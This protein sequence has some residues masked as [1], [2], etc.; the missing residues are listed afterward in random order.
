MHAP[1]TLDFVEIVMVITAPRFIKGTLHHRDQRFGDK[2]KQNSHRQINEIPQHN[3][4]P[5]HRELLPLETITHVNNVDDRQE[6][7]GDE[8]VENREV[9]F[10]LDQIPVIFAHFEDREVSEDRGDRRPR[11]P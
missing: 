11:F 5:D 2:Q 3:Q 10:P 8:N 6:N 7:N 1:K 9:Q 4:R